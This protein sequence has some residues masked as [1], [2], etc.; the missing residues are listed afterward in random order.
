MSESRIRE[1]SEVPLAERWN[2]ASLFPSEAEWEAAFASYAKLRGGAAAHRSAMLGA[3]TGAGAG[4]G[5]GSGADTGAGGGA[6]TGRGAGTDGG[7]EAFLAALAD[8]GVQGLLG[9]RLG[10]YASLRQAEDEGDTASRGRFARFVSAA[11]E[12]EGAWSWFVP[13]IHGLDPS[14]VE[15]WLAD[16]RFAEYR[17]FVRKILRFKPHVLGEAE[18]RLLA[19]QSEANQ[20]AG[21]AFSVLTDV[22]LDFGAVETPEGPRPLTQSTFASLLRHTDRGVRQRAYE[23]F[24]KG[25]DAHRNTLATLYAGSVKL[26][27]YRA[28]VRNFPSSRKAALFPDAVEESVYD[29]LVATVGANLDALHNYYEIR[30]KALGLTELR[31]WDVYVPLARETRG[32]RS[33]EEAVDLVCAALAPLGAAYVDTIRAGFLGDWVDRYENRGKRS[34]AFS[35]GSFSAEPFILMNYKSDVL[36]DVFTLAHEGGHSMH[37]RYSA[38]SNPFLSYDYTIFE[39]E[40][41]ST[42]NEELLFRHL[43]EGAPDEATRLSLMSNRVDSVV[44]TLFRQTMFAEFEHRA[45][46]MQEGGE[47]LTVDSLRGAYRSLLEKYFGPSLVFEGVSDLEGLRIPHFYRAYYVYKYATG[48]S[49]SMALARRVMGGGETERADY[50]AFLKS[51]GSRYPIEALRVAGVD[52]ASPKPIEAACAQFRADLAELERL[53]G[54]ASAT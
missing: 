44:A 38:R 46:L 6:G 20:T 35:S 28:K 17:V 24:Y 16:P 41:A 9:E 7:A 21:E 19:L 23:A 36:H 33:Y 27:V 51:G 3:G 12:L 32:E 42:F 1:R 14:L 11:T 29:N 22:D 13:A 37:S 15:G 40:V 54:A 49:A 43:Y 25:F 52:M 45:H 2:L 5:T 53:L 39:A 30:K 50:F 8:Y 47:A 18:E 26:D 4:A 48:I 10:V 31:H 34:G